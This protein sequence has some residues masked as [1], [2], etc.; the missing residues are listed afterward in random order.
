MLEFII[1]TVT[2]MIIT[3]FIKLLDF[4]PRR[5]NPFVALCLGVVFYAA[6]SGGWLCDSVFR[7]AASG[8]SAGGLCGCVKCMTHESL[9]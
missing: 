2:V 3:E 1:I 5:Y 7:G 6:Y 9:L 8:L 4:L